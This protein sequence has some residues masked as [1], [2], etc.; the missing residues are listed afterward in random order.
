MIENFSS[1][2]RWG[3]FFNYTNGCLVANSAKHERKLNQFSSNHKLRIRDMREGVAAHP[4]KSD[5]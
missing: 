2:N 5:S 4:A 3:V 1:A